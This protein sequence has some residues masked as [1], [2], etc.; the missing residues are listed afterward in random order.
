MPIKKIPLILTIGGF[1]GLHLGHQEIIRR[2]KQIAQKIHGVPG[3][4]T[5]HPLPAQLLHPDFPYLL[6]PI[7]EKIRLLTELGIQFTQVIEFNQQLSATEPEQFIE[8][9]IL[10][11]QPKIIVI[12]SDHHFGRNGRGDTNL[13]FT[14]LKQHG[15]ELDIVPEFYHL[16][17]PV[18][19]T[20]I[21]EHLVLGHIRLA[22]ELLGRLYSFTGKVTTGSG[23][24]RL[25]GFPTINIQPTFREKL[26]PAEGVYAVIVETQNGNFGGVLNIGFRPTFGGGDRTIETHILN[27]PQDAPKVEKIT[28]H[29]LE[30][31]RPET[32]FKN[33]EDLKNQ[34]ARDIALTSKLIKNSSYRS[35]LL[36]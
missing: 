36:P 3:I 29:L 30:R 8:N 6:T 21:R 5:F 22:T 34:I 13:L 33:P 17:A 25:I 12:G 16:G 11:L 27:Y 18:K 15:I 2:V 35:L 9:Y 26:L 19:S 10:P 1:D 31:L 14:I 23:I 24:G 20:R 7:D 28:I 4:I 32:K